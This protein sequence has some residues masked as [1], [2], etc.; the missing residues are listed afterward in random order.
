M[1]IYLIR[2]IISVLYDSSNRKKVVRNPSLFSKTGVGFLFSVF[3][4][5]MLQIRIGLNSP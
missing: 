3:L 5:Q 1:C 2:M 4:N